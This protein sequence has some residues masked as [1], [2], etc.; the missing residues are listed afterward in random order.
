[1]LYKVVLAF[2]YLEATIVFIMLYKPLS[3]SN[4]T[5]DS[6]NFVPVVRRQAERS[7]NEPGH[8][9]SQPPSLEPVGGEKVTRKA[10]LSKKWQQTITTKATK[11]RKWQKQLQW[12]LSSLPL[13][14]LLSRD[15]YQLQDF[16][17]GTDDCENFLKVPI[18]SHWHVT[19]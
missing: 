16:H 11:R 4:F 5:K 8:W 19:T 10:K 7:R 14:V 17:G 18:C 12:L 13:V 2:T 15:S 1:M 9:K 3:R 6:V